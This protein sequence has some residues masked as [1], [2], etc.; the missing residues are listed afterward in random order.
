MP[1]LYYL[2]DFLLRVRFRHDGIDLERLKGV[3][4]ILNFVD[5][6][7]LPRDVLELKSDLLNA[8]IRSQPIFLVEVTL[9]IN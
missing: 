2:T 1:L 6:L 4:L 3:R 5:W 7:L 8:V 9:L